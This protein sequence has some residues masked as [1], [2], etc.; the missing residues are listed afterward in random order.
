MIRSLPHAKLVAGEGQ[1]DL[2]ATVDG[3]Y[4]RTLEGRIDT[5][6]AT[7]SIIELHFHPLAKLL[8]VPRQFAELFEPL[9]LIFDAQR[10]IPDGL[11]IAAG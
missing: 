7:R 9:I 4:V 10:A 1:I 3:E 11:V 5:A 6:A 2:R 8:R